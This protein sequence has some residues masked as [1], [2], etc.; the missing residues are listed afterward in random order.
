MLQFF[1][2]RLDQNKSK[3]NECKHVITINKTTVLQLLEK[4]GDLHYPKGSQYMNPPSLSPPW[5]TGRSQ[6]GVQTKRK[7]YGDCLYQ[8]LKVECPRCST[9]YCAWCSM[10]VMHRIELNWITSLDLKY[11]ESILKM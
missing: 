7:E 2:A 6:E 10:G 8:T 4:M 9:S 5:T 3:T 1:Y 11:I